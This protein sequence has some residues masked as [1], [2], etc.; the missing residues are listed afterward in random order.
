[1]PREDE[2]KRPPVPALLKEDGSGQIEVMNKM[3]K[4]VEWL[5]KHFTNFDNFVCIC[6]KTYPPS[7]K[8]CPNCHPT[9]PNVKR[10]L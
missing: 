7:K 6:G 4:N 9:G 2:I 8:K 3:I 1:M 10:S 5:N